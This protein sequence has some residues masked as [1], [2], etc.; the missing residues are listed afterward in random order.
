M[1]KSLNRVSGF[2]KELCPVCVA[3]VEEQ[4]DSVISVFKHLRWSGFNLEFETLYLSI[5]HVVADL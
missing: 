5:W 2:S 1:K 4:V 3:A